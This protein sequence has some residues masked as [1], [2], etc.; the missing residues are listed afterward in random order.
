MKRKKVMEPAGRDVRQ[1]KAGVP[2]PAYGNGPVA[3]KVSARVRVVRSHL[4]L[5]SWD[6]AGSQAPPGTSPAARFS[7]LTVRTWQKLSVSKI[8]TVAKNAITKKRPVSA[9][10]TYKDNIIHLSLTYD[11]EEDRH[12]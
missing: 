12:E 5:R 8:L 4:E 1:S 2:G 6:I 3:I 9:T 11:V 10:T 7:A